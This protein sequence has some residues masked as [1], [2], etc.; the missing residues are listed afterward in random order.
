MSSPQRPLHRL[1]WTSRLAITDG[2]GLQVP[3]EHTVRRK[4]H[5]QGQ[6][7]AEHGHAAAEDR[8]ALRRQALR[9]P[10]G[11]G[12][13][14]S[15]VRGSHALLACTHTV[16]CG[17]AYRAVGLRCRAR[18]LTQRSDAWGC[19]VMDGVQRA[20]VAGSVCKG[21]D[22]NVARH[23]GSGDLRASSS[24]VHS[25]RPAGTLR[26]IMVT[27]THAHVLCGSWQILRSSVRRQGVKALSSSAHCRHYK[28]LERKASSEERWQFVALVDTAAAWVWPAVLAAA[29]ARARRTCR[30]RRILEFYAYCTAVLC[31]SLWCQSRQP[32][33]KRFERIASL[34]ALRTVLEPVAARAPPSTSRIEHSRAVLPPQ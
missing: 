13:W 24:P 6:Q 14:L 23:A 2:G 25:K 1:W 17:A 4:W 8:L 5:R 26:A 29:C 20:C 19:P 31:A 3:D 30:I 33:S 11:R 22:T 28:L 18:A 16:D 7:G 34:L 15:F 27:E 21:F 10:I 32:A 12:A 9:Q